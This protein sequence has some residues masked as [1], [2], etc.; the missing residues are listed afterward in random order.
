MVEPP[1]NTTAGFLARFVE[2]LLGGGA[3][4]VEAPLSAHDR[5]QMLADAGPLTHPSFLHLRMRLGRRLVAEPALPDPGADELSLWLGLH[6]VLALDHPDTERVWTRASTW[7]RVETETR[8]LLAFARPGDMAEAFARELAVGAF[9]QLRREDHVVSGPAG[10]LRFR[11]QTPPRRRFGLFSP[12]FADVRTEVVRW[13][14]QPHATIVDRLLPDVMWVS[15]L[16]S[17]LRPAWAP[18]GWSP[19]MA[20]EFLQARAYARAVCHAWAQER[21]WLRIGGVVAGSLLRS[22]DLQGR[23]FGDLS[24]SSVPGSAAAMQRAAKA[25]QLGAGVGVGV[26]V[27][28]GSTARSGGASEDLDDPDDPDDPDQ[29]FD[30]VDREFAEEP[31][32]VLAALPAPAIPSAPAD[33]GAVVGALIHL[34]VLK[35]LEFDA[36]ISIGVG[37]RDWAVQTFLALPLLLPA[38]ERT[39]GR[40]FDL[41]GAAVGPRPGSSGALFAGGA[42]VVDEGFARRWNEYGEHLA[43]L[44]PRNVVDNLHATL[45]RRIRE[46]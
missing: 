36:R 37:A 22:L 26:G 21:E 24:I 10:D 43:G 9:L 32:G 46:E 18:P 45:V 42:G 23:V 29:S 41:D 28:V 11:G 16:T 34:H 35:V 30:Q 1:F 25:A 40:P 5:E 2:P 6:D 12:G 4:E 39:L 38:L 7:R 31:S 13:I 27:G 15:P 17:L 44:V 3:V 8:S 33:I 19:L 20:V 14:D